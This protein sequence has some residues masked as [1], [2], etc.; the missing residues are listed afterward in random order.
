MPDTRRRATESTAWTQDGTRDAY[1]LPGKRQEIREPCAMKVA[2]TVRGGAD[3][4]G[5]VTQNLASRLL[6]SVTIGVSPRR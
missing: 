3:G 5:L 4:K 1:R 6:Y 2:S